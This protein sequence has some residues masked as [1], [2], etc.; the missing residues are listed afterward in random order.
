MC[1]LKEARCI[2]D[3]RCTLIHDNI[4]MTRTE[5]K[6]LSSDYTPNELVFSL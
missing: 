4:G 3:G 1:H 6:E 2:T 5:S